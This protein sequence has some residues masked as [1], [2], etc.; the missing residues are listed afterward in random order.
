MPLE[1]GVPDPVHAHHPAEVVVIQDFEP[2]DRRHS[3]EQD[4]GKNQNRD[5]DE[6]LPESIGLRHEGQGDH[7]AGEDRQEHAHAA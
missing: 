6:S 7:R 3:N 4:N 5:Q 1:I 2:D